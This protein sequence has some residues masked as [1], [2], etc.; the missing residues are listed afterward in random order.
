MMR[1]GGVDQF[2]VGNA[3]DDHL[4]EDDMLADHRLLFWGELAGLAQDGVRHGDLADVM[5]LT[6]DV[7]RIDLLR[8]QPRNRPRRTAYSA[9]RS[10]WSLV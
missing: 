6:S 5:Q 2:E 4:A 9:T 7:Q 1:D 8:R 3:L 10:E